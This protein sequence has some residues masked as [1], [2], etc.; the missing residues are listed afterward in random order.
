MDFLLQEITAIL[1]TDMTEAFNDWSSVTTYHIEEDDATLSS[2]SVARDGNY[3]YRTTIDSNINNRPS[4]TERLY[5]TV[6]APSN[7]YAMI[8]ASANTS[9]DLDGIGFYVT[10]AR[11]NIEQLAIGNVVAESI[12][13]ENLDA[14][15]N[16]LATQ[17]IDTSATNEEVSD[18]W[19]YLY[20]PYDHG[21]DRGFLVNIAPIGTNIKITFTKHIAEDRTSCGYLVG[22]QPISFGK[23]L[24]APSFK[25]NSIGDSG[26]D[27]WG[28]LIENSILPQDAVDFE[29]V[30][31]TNEFVAMRRK[32]KSMYKEV[33]VFIL[34][35]SS[36]S[37]HENLLTLGVVMDSSQVL[38]NPSTSTISWSIAEVI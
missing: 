32:L 12:T 21:I 5:W 23:T 31:D 29:T 6:H 4:L 14:S 11:G 16:V 27:E 15:N 20:S 24:Y 35:E 7:R 37:I 28:R 30:V 17:T 33:G 36:D 1:D 38:S 22:G 3:Y 9:T 2:V 8:D 26:F 19:S 13:I 34:D 25:Y 18:Y 10:V